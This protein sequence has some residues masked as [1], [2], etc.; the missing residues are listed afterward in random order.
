MKDQ[1]IYDNDEFFDGYK[2]LRENPIAANDIVEKPAL[3]LLCPDFVGKT[4]LDLGCGYG[5]NCQ[6]FSRSGARKQCL[7]KEESNHDF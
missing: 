5:E 4:V 2:K 1:N 6:E 3:F 7:Q